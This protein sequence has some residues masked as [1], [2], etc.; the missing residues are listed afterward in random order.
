MESLIT[1]ITTLPSVCEAICG[2]LMILVTA[3]PGLIEVNKLASARSR[4][5]MRSRR[6]LSTTLETLSVIA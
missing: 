2:S 6:R 4:P 5:R 1:E 3:R